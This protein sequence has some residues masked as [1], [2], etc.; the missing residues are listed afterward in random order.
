M[1]SPS[2][3]LKPI[4]EVINV[5]AYCIHTSNTP[6]IQLFAHIIHEIDW[7]HRLSQVFNVISTSA[8]FEVLYIGFNLF[9]IF[10]II[11]TTPSIAGF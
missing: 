10:E 8:K 7:L 4:R 6:F 2:L 5:Q 1:P 11:L 9:E 3:L